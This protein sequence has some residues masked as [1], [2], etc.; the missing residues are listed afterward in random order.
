MSRRSFFDSA[1]LLCAAAL[2]SGGCVAP[3]AQYDLGALRPG[4]D[5]EIRVIVRH[6]APSGIKTT[7]VILV[8]E[9]R[10]DTY[11]KDAVPCGRRYPA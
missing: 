2:F 3:Q 8:W 6:F 10:Y 5:E 7:Y 9:S 4:S 1:I 11:I